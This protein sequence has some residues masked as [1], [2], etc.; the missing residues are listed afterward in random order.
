MSGTEARELRDCARKFTVG[1][2]PKNSLDQIGHAALARP[3]LAL[4]L[5]APIDESGGYAER[6]KNE[7]RIMRNDRPESPMRRGQDMYRDAR[8]EERRVGKEWRSRWLQ[9]R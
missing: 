9:E 4:F 2:R 7:K 5:V 6:G 1:T 8:S 3:A